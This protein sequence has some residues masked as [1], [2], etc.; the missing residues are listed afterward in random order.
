MMKSLVQ[1]VLYMTILS[2]HAK[3]SRSC[4]KR[5]GN[6]RQRRHCLTSDF[7]SSYMQS[8]HSFILQQSFSLLLCRRCFVAWYFLVLLL[9]V[10]SLVQRGK[11]R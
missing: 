6:T 10:K 1:N 8:F 11:W 2:R 3:R 4:I 7:N 5:L 9:H